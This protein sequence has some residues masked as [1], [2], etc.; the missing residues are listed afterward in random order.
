MCLQQLASAPLLNPEENCTEDVSCIHIQTGAG[1]SEPTASSLLT[2][3]DWDEAS[4]MAT[5]VN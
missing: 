2:V 5:V 4:V 3:L 1:Y